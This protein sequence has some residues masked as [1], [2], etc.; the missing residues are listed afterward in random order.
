M[1][2]AWQR[3]LE[4]KLAWA[5]G[6]AYGVEYKASRTL[7]KRSASVLR[8]YAEDLMECLKT[9]EQVE[10]EFDAGMDALRRRSMLKT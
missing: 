6:T 10:E 4:N 7:P 3:E 8:A 2:A 5:I 1:L 9:N